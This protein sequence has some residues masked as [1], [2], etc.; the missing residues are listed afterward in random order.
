MNFFYLHYGL[1]NADVERY[2]NA[3]LS[4]GGD[5]AELY[6][7]HVTSS[8][9][10]MNRSALSVSSYGISGGC[11]VRVIA[12]EHTGYAYTDE[13]TPKRILGAAHAASLIANGPTK[14]PIVRFLQA[15]SESAYPVS[16]PSV[17]VD[18][19][20][21]V[22]L[23]LRAESAAFRYDSRVTDVRSAFMDELKHVLIIGSDGTFAADCQPLARF[24]AVVQVNGANGAWAWSSG[25]SGGR[26]GVGHFVSQTPDSTL[27]SDAVRRALAELDARQSP[28]GE[29]A[30]VFGPGCGVLYALAAGHGFEGDKVRKGNSTFAG[31]LGQ[32]VARDTCTL[33]DDATV[34]WSRGSLNVDD[35]G[36]PGQR[37]VLVENG[38]LKCW[39]TGQAYFAPH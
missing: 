24:R 18:M 20:D 2:L 34:P 22:E 32:R 5:Y 10:S 31:M 30:V 4:S 27:A 38:I 36:R 23:L 35:E 21:K 13:L 39:L 29:M 25:N 1:T 19:K 17:D 33:V 12:G 14:T 15:S 7:E 8:S 37:T 6:F 28:A 16:H 9:I 3:A 26:V 11:G